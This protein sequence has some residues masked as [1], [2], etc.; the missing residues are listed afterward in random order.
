M[1]DVAEFLFLKI[2]FVS[3][4]ELGAKSCSNCSTISVFP[5]TRLM[6]F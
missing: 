4:E 5:L 6:L 1:S 3:M 2:L